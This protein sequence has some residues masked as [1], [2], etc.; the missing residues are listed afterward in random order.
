MKWHDAS[1]GEIVARDGGLIQTGPFGSQLHQADY[2]PDG[3]PVI[4][5]K[6]IAD[7]CVSV[8][9]IARISEETANRLERHKIKPRSIVLPRRGEVTKRAFIRA[10]QEGWLCGTGCLKIEINGKE[11]APKFLYYFM[12]QGHVVQ[13]L[14]QHAVGTTML[15]L[16]AGIVAQLPIRYPAVEAQVEIASTLSTYDDLIENNRRRMALLEESARL[17]YREWFVRLRFPGHEHTRIVDGVPEG[18]EKH[19]IG[20]IADCVGGGTPST[21]VSTY[22]EDGTITWVTPTDVT[23]NQHFVLLEAEKKITEAGLK[24]SSAKLVPPHTILMTSRASVG[25]FAITGRE[26]CTNQGFISIV[27]QDV[28]L[29]AFLLFQLSERVEEIRAMGSGSTYPEVSR[30]KFRDFQILI[31]PKRL[32]ADF[33]EQVTLLFK[34]IRVLK[35]QNKKLRAARDLLLPRLM[36]GEIAV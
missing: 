31:P 9:S 30:S 27:P 12:E 24:N 4:M 35:Q 8:E 6:D 18:W 13:W 15:N 23:R 5:P 26:V 29:S 7:G 20:D 19:R 2:Q 34:Q 14:E 3:I 36:S 21:T 1:L 28:M 22:W 25:F 16:S 33:D 11:L 17:L 10:E 32:I